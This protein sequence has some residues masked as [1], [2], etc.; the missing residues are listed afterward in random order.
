MCLETTQ[1]RFPVG[2][3]KYDTACFLS[4]YFRSRKKLPCI[5]EYYKTSM[6]KYLLLLRNVYAFEGFLRFF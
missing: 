3:W 4:Y 1:Y 2:K 5:F 6:N